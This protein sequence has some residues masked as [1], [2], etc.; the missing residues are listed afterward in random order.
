MEKGNYSGKAANF[1]HSCEEQG[2]SR[3]DPPLFR[4]A[5]QKWKLT[6]KKDS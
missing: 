3:A 6:L 1:W 2:K 4:N 5:I